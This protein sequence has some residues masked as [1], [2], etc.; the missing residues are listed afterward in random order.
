MPNPSTPR[1]KDHLPPTGA[2]LDRRSTRLGSLDPA[3]EQQMAA[4]ARSTLDPRGE[5]LFLALG[6]YRTT[7]ATDS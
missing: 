6:Y 2:Q 4:W 3:I 7:T 1:I 5:V